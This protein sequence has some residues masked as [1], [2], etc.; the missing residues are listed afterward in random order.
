MPLGVSK[1]LSFATKHRGPKPE[2]PALARLEK[3]VLCASSKRNVASVVISGL[4]SVSRFKRLFAC[5]T[6]APL[7][8]VIV[9]PLAARRPAF[10]LCQRCW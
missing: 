9:Q 5:W 10:R 4:A 6:R 1:A 2:D 3:G 7:P 8:A